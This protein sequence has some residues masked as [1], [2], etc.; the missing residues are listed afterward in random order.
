MKFIKINL[1]FIII[2]FSLFL[3]K[4]GQATV[5]DNCSEDYECDTG[6][7]CDITEQQ[8]NE[9]YQGHC[10]RNENCTTDSDCGTGSVCQS[11]QCISGSREN[12]GNGQ[13]GDR[14]TRDSDCESGLTCTSNQCVVTSHGTGS[15]G[16]AVFRNPLSS[17]TIP[18]LISTVL[19]YV[20]GLVGVLAVASLVYGGILYMASGGNE[21]QLNKGKKVLTYS[22]IGLVVSILSYVIVNTIIRAIGG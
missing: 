4:F 16:T 17:N 7:R 10:V 14:C 3:V 1:I 12:I 20:L 2:L 5:G 21:D 15:G 11:G 18:E 19:N 6:E 9:G 8:R 13:E 22:I